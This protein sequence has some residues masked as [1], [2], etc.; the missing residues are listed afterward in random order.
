M[1]TPKIASVPVKTLKNS[2]GSLIHL[3]DEIIASIDFAITG[4]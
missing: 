4:I 3:R 1:L 2:I